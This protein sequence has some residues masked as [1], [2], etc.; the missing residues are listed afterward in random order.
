MW[1]V[2]GREH[3]IIGVMSVVAEARSTGRPCSW[4]LCYAVHLSLCAHLC[5]CRVDRS[6]VGCKSGIR[7]VGGDSEGGRRR[8]SCRSAQIAGVGSLNFVQTSCHPNDRSQSIE[9]TISRLSD[10][11]ISSLANS[12][13]LPDV[14]EWRHFSIDQTDRPRQKW[15]F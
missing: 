9:R 4:H 8:R 15:N 2:R 7:V 11:P 12:S 10:M 3:S 6:P 14:R 5:F 13:M 1:N